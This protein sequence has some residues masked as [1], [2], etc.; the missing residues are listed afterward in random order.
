MKYFE[1]KIGCTTRL[2]KPKVVTDSYTYQLGSPGL[3][4]YTFDPMDPWPF[5]G[6]PEQVINYEAKLLSGLPMPSGISFLPYTRTFTF[7]DD[8][9]I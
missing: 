3:F 4:S 1:V 9:S 5:C 2:I 7:S 6:T 8:E